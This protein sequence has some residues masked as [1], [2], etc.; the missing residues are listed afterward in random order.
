LPADPRFV[1]IVAPHTSNWDFV[2]GVAAMFALD[3]RVHWLG[4]HTLFRW[5]L[6]PLLRWLGGQP[7]RRDS[8]HGVVA[9]VADAIRAEPQFILA[10]AP[11]GTRRHVDAWRTGFYHIARRADIPIVPVALDWGRREIIIAVP[12]QPS[13]DLERDVAG[14]R[15][16]YK[17]EMARRAGGF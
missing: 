8:A 13:G 7:V 11:E 12:M 16:R 2:I 4:K 10:L 9:E 6:G 1:A 3:V 15:A 17:L 14:L 5:P